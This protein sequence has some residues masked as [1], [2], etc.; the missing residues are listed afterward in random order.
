VYWRRWGTCQP[1]ACVIVADRFYGSSQDS[2]KHSENSACTN[3]RY[4]PLNCSAQEDMDNSSQ[5]TM[6]YC[7]N[8]TTTRKV[9]IAMHCNSKAAR[10]RSSHS[11]LFWPNL[12]RACVDI[13]TFELPVNPVHIVIPP[14][15][16]ATRIP[17][18]H[19]ILTIGGHLHQHF[20]HIFTAHAQKLLFPSFRS[21]FFLHR[22]LHAAIRTRRT[23]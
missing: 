10:R 1:R 13:A 16:L 9:A 11:G 14:L 4:A 15:D 5:T 3:C 18:W 23:S 7:H 19:D 12:Y 22:L 21:K 2:S 20:G 8:F 17:I 6:K